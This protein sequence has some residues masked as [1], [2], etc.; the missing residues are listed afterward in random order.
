M[1][2]EKVR[3]FKK[4]FHGSITMRTNVFGI[5]LGAA[6]GYFIGKKCGF[7][8]SSNKDSFDTLLLLSVAAGA[9]S[10]EIFHISRQKKWNFGVNLIVTFG[11]AA[12]L[13]CAHW[14]GSLSAFFLG[15]TYYLGFFVLTF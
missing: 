7:V 9:L 8:F 4:D 2:E 1:N 10:E 11:V 6:L 3:V 13:S 12:I 14:G 15:L 5:A